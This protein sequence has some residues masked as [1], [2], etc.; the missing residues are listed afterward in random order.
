MSGEKRFDTVPFEDGVAITGYHGSEEIVWIPPELEGLPVRCIRE[1]AFEEAEMTEIV[2]P[3][4]VRIIERK[5]CSFCFL[6]QKVTLPENLT[7]LDGDSFGNAPLQELRLPTTLCRLTR[8][9]YLN[10]CIRVEGHPFLFVQNNGLY[11]RKPDGAHFLCASETELQDLSLCEGTVEV[12]EGALRQAGLSSVT[13]PVSLQRLPEAEL[14]GIQQINMQN[15]PFL[16]KEDGCIYHSTSRGWTLHAVLMDTDCLTVR[17]GTQII[18]REAFYGRNIRKAVLPESIREIHRNAFAGVPL[19]EVVLRGQSIVFP[20][21]K[22][23]RDEL[24]SAFDEHSGTYHFEAMDRVLL[25]DY[26]NTDRLH[27]LVER[28]HMP[29]LPRNQQDAFSRRLQDTLPEMLPE[30]VKEKKPELFESALD[31]AAFSA[32]QRDVL[33]GLLEKMMDSGAAREMM[34]ILSRNKSRNSQKIREGFEL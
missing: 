27:M 3:E 15:T 30:L 18:G 16:Q 14:A 8:P 2:F 7:D 33:Y 12:E 26:M 19:Q 11:A 28:M 1:G 21:E 10:A 32:V 31:G 25:S 34:V 20:E 6:L 4:T 24:L 5:A 22:M 17:P 29:G 9:M 13:L 23:L